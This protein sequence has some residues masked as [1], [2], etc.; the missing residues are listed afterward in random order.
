LI[1]GAVLVLVLVVV[2][3]GGFF[4]MNWLK[5]KAD[6]SSTGGTAGSAKTV[7]PRDWG[8]YWLAV[9]TTEKAEAIRAGAV[10][11]MK[12]GQDFKFHFQPRDSGYLYIIG[13]G[14]DNAPTAFLTARP[15]TE[16]GLKTNEVNAGVDFTFPADTSKDE[17]WVTLDKKPGTE[18][19]TIIFSPK[20]LVSP[21]FLTSEATGQP[22][23]ETEKAE[24]NAFLLKY[25]TNKPVAEVNNNDPATPFVTLKM[26]N[27]NDANDVGRPVV[28]EVKIQHN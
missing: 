23:S 6:D 26:P 13:P 10:V 8:R 17:H 27:S 28:F 7:A 15:G 9:R 2:G 16:S 21:G 22:L 4:A 12:S 11:S 19:Y 3:I 18:N 1:G 14:N 5:P 20:P 24:L 25:E